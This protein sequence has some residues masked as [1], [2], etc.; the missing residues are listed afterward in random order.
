VGTKVK[1]KRYFTAYDAI[2][3]THHYKLRG[4]V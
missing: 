2:N 1:G 4:Y 3:T